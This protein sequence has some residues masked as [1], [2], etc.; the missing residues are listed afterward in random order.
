M[1]TT[2]TKTVTVSTPEF[3]AKYRDIAKFEGY[4]H[5]CPN[6]NRCYSCPPHGFDVASYLDGYAHGV[7]IG[8]KIILDPQLLQKP[9][10]AAER[11][12]FIEDLT[13]DYRRLLDATILALEQSIDGAR[14]CFAGP[15]QFCTECAKVAGEPCRFPQ[16]RRPSLESIGFDLA[17]TSK[18]LLGIELQW[19]RDALP[20]YFT[21]ISALFY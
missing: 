21:L 17:A 4:C 1:F 20:P 19:S 6:Y 11:D 8:T 13:H 18:E 7:I 5:Q 12:R 14:G 10:S 16:K 15:C 9:L 2:E 3:I